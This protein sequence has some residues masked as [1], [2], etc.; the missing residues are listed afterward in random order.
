MSE[1]K[2]AVPVHQFVRSQAY[3]DVYSNHTKL[4][5]T[6]FDISIIFGR[7][8]EFPGMGNV[9]EDMGIVRLSPAHFKLLTASLQSTLENWEKLFGEITTIGSEQDKKN[10]DKFFGELKGRLKS[11]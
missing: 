6:P 9:I 10:M 11:D 2:Q 5:I 4:Q 7:I 3:F 1:N 8:D